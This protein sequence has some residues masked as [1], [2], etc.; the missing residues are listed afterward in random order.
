MAR[1]AEIIGTKVRIVPR[2]ISPWLTSR[3]LMV[4]ERKTYLLIMYRERPIIIMLAEKR[5]I[6]SSSSIPLPKRAVEKGTTPTKRKKRAF[7]LVSVMSM[8]LA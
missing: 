1:A 7:M 6:G 3:F 8:F 4:G 2:A 5:I